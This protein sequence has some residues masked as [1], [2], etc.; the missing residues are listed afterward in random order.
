MTASRRS[1]K[2]RDRRAPIP[3]FDD[4][5]PGSHWLKRNAP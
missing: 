1:R 5:Q 3:D 4:P 2:R